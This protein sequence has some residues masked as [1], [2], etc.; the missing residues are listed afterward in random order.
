MAKKRSFA[1]PQLGWDGK[2]RSA[3]ERKPLTRDKWPDII[4]STADRYV[5]EPHCGH[6]G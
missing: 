4:E 6:W 5:G 2:P 1:R 3:S